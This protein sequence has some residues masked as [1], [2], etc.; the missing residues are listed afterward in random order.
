MFETGRFS[1]K[2]KLE[3][4]KS[5]YLVGSLGLEFGWGEG[6]LRTFSFPAEP[7]F[8]ETKGVCV[9]HGILLVTPCSPGFDENCTR[10][11]WLLWENPLDSLGISY[12]DF[13]IHQVDQR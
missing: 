1:W 11:C 6:V 13:L 12:K 9:L 4:R 3:I 2:L 5:G 8:F 7:H 10:F